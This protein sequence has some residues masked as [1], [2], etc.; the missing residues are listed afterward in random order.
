MCI[1]T[2]IQSYS[3]SKQEEMN[4]DR[5]RDY[6]SGEENQNRVGGSEKRSKVGAVGSGKTPS[7]PF[8]DSLSDRS[9]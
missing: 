9:F 2:N 5:K 1:Q 6:T 8:S 4:R 7:E 3:E